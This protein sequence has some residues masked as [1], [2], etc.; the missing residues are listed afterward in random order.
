MYWTP[1]VVGLGSLA[2]VSA[3]AGGER[4]AIGD[5]LA[6]APGMSFL[7]GQNEIMDG[8]WWVSWWC[9]GFCW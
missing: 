7:E 8:G 5:V 2:A 9:Y 4:R 6:G 3:S 1:V